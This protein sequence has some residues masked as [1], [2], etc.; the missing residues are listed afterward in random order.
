MIIPL[1]AAAQ[2]IDSAADDHDGDDL[3][4]TMA[5]EFGAAAV[6][7]EQTGEH[8]PKEGRRDSRQR[9]RFL[10]RWPDPCGRRTN[11]RTQR[12]QMG[13]GGAAQGRAHLTA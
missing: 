6:V 13:W 10:T 12:R 11:E 7:A 2:H 4:S 8:F 9:R 5:D 1:T 3:D